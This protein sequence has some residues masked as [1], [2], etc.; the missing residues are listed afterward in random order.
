MANTIGGSK[1]FVPR[2]PAKGSFPLDHFGECKDI[3]SDYMKCLK[4]KNSDASSCQHLAKDYLKC[5][6]DNE[7]MAKED[8]KYLG[9]QDETDNKKE[10]NVE[11]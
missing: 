4:K 2:P 3:M 9:F 5:R 10:A 8:F 1:L 7:L 11:K 6:M